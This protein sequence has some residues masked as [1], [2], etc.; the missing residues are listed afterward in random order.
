[1]GD[2]RGDFSYMLGGWYSWKDRRGKTLDGPRE[3]WRPS[4]STVKAFIKFAIATD[5]RAHNIESETEGSVDE[6]R[7]EVIVRRGKTDSSVY[8]TP[9]WARVR[10]G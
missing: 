10:T 9:I 2:R 8:F 7:R 1:M 5:K 4:V 6:Q 3:N